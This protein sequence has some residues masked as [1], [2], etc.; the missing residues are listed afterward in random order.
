M[1]T[2]KKQSTENFIKEIRRKARRTFSSE[3]KS[4]QKRMSSFFMIKKIKF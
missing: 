3:Q 1:E 2:K 4:M